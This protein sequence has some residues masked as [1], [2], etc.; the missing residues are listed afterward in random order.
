MGQERGTA[1]GRYAGLKWSAG[2]AP[3]VNLGEHT[4]RMPLPSANKAAHSGFETQRRGYQIDMYPPKTFKNK[5]KVIHQQRTSMCA[6]TWCSVRP[7]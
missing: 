5:N 4:S 7:R 2:V 1:T 6:L 3:E